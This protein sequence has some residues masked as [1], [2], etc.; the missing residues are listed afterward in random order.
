MDDTTDN[1]ESKQNNDDSSDI[2][3]Q[4]QQK[5]K[6][7]KISRKKRVSFGAN[8][9][10][11][12]KKS[13]SKHKKRIR[14]RDRIMTLS[15][16]KN[17]ESVSKTAFLA[18][19]LMEAHKIVGK[20]SFA[21]IHRCKQKNSTTILAMKIIKKK[22]ASKSDIRAMRR[23]INALAL[24]D[25]KNV[26]NIHDWCETPST[27]YIVLDYCGGGNLLERVSNTGKFTELHTVKVILQVA[28]ALQHVHSLGIVHRDL[29]VIIYPIYFLSENVCLYIY[30]IE[31][32]KYTQ[33]TR[34][35]NVYGREWK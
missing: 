6:K 1:D 9:I 27:L 35:Y 28:D 4:E 22:K 5:K 33:K 18:K 10:K 13:K 11:N 34:K 15:E 30:Y 12:D 16:L 2:I 3:P 26:V 25:H 24:I 19:Y 29:Y 17:L 32:R 7:K 21:K 23:E 20:G 8:P 14:T 31:K